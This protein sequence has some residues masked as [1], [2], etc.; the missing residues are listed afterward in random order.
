MTKFTSFSVRIKGTDIF[1]LRF[2]TSSFNHDCALRDRNTEAHG[3]ALFRRFILSSVANP[4]LVKLKDIIICFALHLISNNQKKEK[5]QSRKCKITNEGGQYQ[6][7]TSEAALLHEVISQCMWSLAAL[8]NS[9]SNLRCNYP[10]LRQTYVDW[11]V[12][13]SNSDISQTKNE[14]PKHIFLDRMRFS[15]QVDASAA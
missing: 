11:W 8:P 1:F 2:H 13:W 9:W 14:L 4:S 15:V 3:P 12:T 6:S 7:M 10:M 5:I